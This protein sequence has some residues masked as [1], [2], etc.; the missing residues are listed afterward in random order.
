M[1]SCLLLPLLL[2]LA[3][4][5]SGGDGPRL[6]SASDEPERTAVPP[7]P[8][9]PDESYTLCDTS[10]ADCQA[11]LMS[12]AACLRESDPVEGLTID[13][14]TPEE[15]ISLLE[16]DMEGMEP[17]PPINHHERAL[18]VLSLTLAEG[19]PQD[20]GLAN[21]VDYIAGM[22]RSSEKRIII[23]DKD[24]PSD[25]VRAF[26]LLLHEMIH[27]LQDADY[28]L[29]TWVGY[30][31]P[32][33]DASLAARSVVEGEA[34]FYQYRAAMPLLGLNHNTVDFWEAM[35]SQWSFDISYAYASPT[36][37]G[38]SFLSFPY[39]LGAPRAYEAWRGQG[40]SGIAALF[41]SPPT[42]TWEIMTRLYLGT[43]ETFEL[44]EIPE[45]SVAGLTLDSDDTLGAWGLEMF[46]NKAGVE[47][48][49]TRN[50]ALT[51]RGDRVWVYTDEATLEQT[52][53]LWQLQLSNTVQAEAIDAVMPDLASA[54]H[55]TQGNRVFV[56]I[57]FETTPSA[58]LTEWGKTWIAEAE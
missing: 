22:Y 13:F 10:D 37:Y 38:A 44:V 34:K 45:P 18:S 52:Y 48:P 2:A 25:D 28:D 39:G 47:W 32:T 26:T 33:F 40:P 7:L 21:H 56:S 35:A 19:V 31:A 57:G 20:E 27:A 51:W 3:A 17:E 8:E 4:C 14:L 11:G 12:L 50:N 55:G 58:D 24:R 36:P 5:S 42:T 41:A 49:D 46:L 53:A 15:T 23:I 43:D 16:Q 30:D 29:Q 54:E 1:K 6:D 9:C